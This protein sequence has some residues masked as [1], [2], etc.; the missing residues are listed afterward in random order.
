[1]RNWFS[2][3]CFHMQLVPLYNGE[4]AAKTSSQLAEQAEKAAE[5]AAAQK[6]VAKK[7]A[8]KMADKAVE[9][10]ATVVKVAEVEEK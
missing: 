5:K 3:L 10:A 7:E 9:S 8:E 4:L 2:S 1:M 6:A